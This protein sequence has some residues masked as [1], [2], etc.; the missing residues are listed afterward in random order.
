MWYGNGTGMHL[1]SVLVLSRGRILMIK[2]KWVQHQQSDIKTVLQ[3]IEHLIMDLF[4]WQTELSSWLSYLEHLGYKSPW[5]T[6]V[7]L[8]TAPPCSLAIIVSYLVL[9]YQPDLNISAFRLAAISSCT[10]SVQQQVLVSSYQHVLD[11]DWVYIQTGRKPNLSDLTSQ[12][13]PKT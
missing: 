12:H 4:Q 7:S 3:F 2:E 10:T 11:C 5:V 6:L 13:D 8:L 9:T 1:V